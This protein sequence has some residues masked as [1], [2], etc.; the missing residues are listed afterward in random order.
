MGLRVDF[1]E[2]R[3][4]LLALRF[5]MVINFEGALRS[6]EIWIG[7]IVV[8]SRYLLSV[9]SKTDNLLD[10]LWRVWIG[11]TSDG[12]WVDAKAVR[13]ATVLLFG[14]VISLSRIMFTKHMSRCVVKFVH[15]LLTFGSVI[16][17]EWVICNTFAVNLFTGHNIWSSRVLVMTEFANRVEMGTFHL[18]RLNV[19]RTFC[20]TRLSVFFG[21]LGVDS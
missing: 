6:Q 2:I 17:D 19:S 3:D 8:I 1:L 12:V 16:I 14:S 11:I 15:F 5:G 9:E 13:E 7:I 4:E 21:I 10:N 18:L 20:P